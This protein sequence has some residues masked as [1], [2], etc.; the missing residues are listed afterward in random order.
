MFSFYQ[1][2]EEV[3]RYENSSLQELILGPTL[4]VVAGVLGFRHL[5]KKGRE[6]DA[7]LSCKSECSRILDRKEWEK[8]VTAC[9]DRKMVLL[10]HQY[11]MRRKVRKEQSGVQNV[12]SY[13]VAGKSPFKTLASSDPKALISMSPYRGR[14]VKEKSRV[15]LP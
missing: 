1:L 15:S 14:K 3:E 13:S 10:T 9:F 6:R 12:D 5:M 11:K 4:G 8:C 2:L 7:M